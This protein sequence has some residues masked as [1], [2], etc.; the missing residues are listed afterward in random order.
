M[1]A[2]FRA[3]L[4]KMPPPPKA[5][6][7]KLIQAAR[8]F[9][10]EIVKPQFEQAVA[11]WQGEKPLWEVVVTSNQYGIYANVRPKQPNSKGA[12]KFLWT[13]E[14]TQAHVIRPKPGNKRGLLSFNLN[15]QAGSVPGVRGSTPASATGPRVFAK[16]VHHPGTEARGWTALIR[17]NAAGVYPRYMQSIFD[18]IAHSMG[19][20]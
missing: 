8:D 19:A 3:I 11:G 15:Y 18:E 7:A 10:M 2:K 5:N 16:E 4:P 20:R 6:R 14:G 13:D 12:L 1:P 9:C 17:D